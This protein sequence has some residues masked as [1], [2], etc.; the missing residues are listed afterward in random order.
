MPWSTRELAELAS[1]TVNTVRHYH[2]LGL[3]D[4]PERRANGYK[5]YGVRHLVRLL[6]IRRLTELGVPLSRIGEVG[7]G[8]R[9]TTADALRAL[10]A[11]LGATIERLQRA[12]SGIAAIL[13][14]GA[15]ADIPAGFEPMASRLSEADRS[16]ILVS[17]QLYDEGAMADLRQM[18]ENDDIAVNDAFNAL[19]PDADE[20]ARQSL[21]ERIA[22]DIERNL[23]RYPWL[24]D[25]AGR[26]AKG[27]RVAR[28]AFVEAVTELYTPAQCDVL[29]RAATLAQERLRDA[30]GADG[31]PG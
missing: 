29:A 10:D 30:R 5:Q 20:A 26:L 7:T 31:E 21:A 16:L 25:P 9:D 24:N 28:E 11:E 4:E 17:T 3:L 1:T 8:D 23:A 2:R 12:R 15:P 27:E 6:R 13:R 19:P 18:V 22:P 14:D